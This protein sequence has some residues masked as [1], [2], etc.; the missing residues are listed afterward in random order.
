MPRITPEKSPEGK[1]KDMLDA[2]NKKIGMTPNIYAT[3]AKAPNVLEFA[4]TGGGFLKQG[5]LP[6]SLQEQIALTSAGYNGC[7]YCAS[8]H[9]LIGKGA[10][11]S[12]AEATSA[13]SAKSADP[14]AQAALTFVKTLI[15]KRGRVSDSDYQAVKAAGYSEGEI[16]EIIAVTA[17]NTFTNYFNDVVETEIDFPKVSSQGTA[18]AA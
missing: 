9:T 13:L 7:D 2:V 15:E 3:M 14:R 10:G 4:L 11:L 12:E 6:A 17:F 8:A 1:A 5:T 18:K 16:I